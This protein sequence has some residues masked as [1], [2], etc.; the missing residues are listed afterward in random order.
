MNTAPAA[1]LPQLDSIRGLAAVAIV[2]YHFCSVL[3]PAL[4]SP[5]IAR[6]YLAVDIFFVLS[7]FVMI[8]VYG[9]AFSTG[10]A[11]TDVL[12]FLRARF[13]R[14]YP[15]HLATLLSMAYWHWPSGAARWRT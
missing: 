7:G 15:L 14:I 13:A 6:F 10:I 8:H 4:I 9:A 2:I 12:N 5:I 11:V 3:L 1:R